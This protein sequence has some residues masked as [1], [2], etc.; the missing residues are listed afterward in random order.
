MICVKSKYDEKGNLLSRISSGE[1]IFP[2]LLEVEYDD[3]GNLISQS[4]YDRIVTEDGKENKKLKLRTDVVYDDTGRVSKITTPELISIHDYKEVSVYIPLIHESLESSNISHTE[5]LLKDANGNDRPDTTV[6]SIESSGEE[7]I[8]ILTIQYDSIRV[9]E[10]YEKGTN[11]LICTE[12]CFFN[13]KNIV[14]YERRDNKGEVSN[15]RST[16][17]Y[18]SEGNIIFIDMEDYS[19]LKTEIDKFEYFQY[20]KIEE[21]KSYNNVSKKI[22]DM[23]TE[24]TISEETYEVEINTIEK[25]GEEFTIIKNNKSVFDCDTM[26]E[27][28]TFTILERTYDQ[29]YRKVKEVNNEDNTISYYSYDDNDDRLTRMVVKHLNTNKKITPFKNKNEV[30]VN[31]D[32]VLT[33]LSTFEDKIIDLTLTKYSNG[34]ISKDVKISYMDELNFE[35]KEIAHYITNNGED[36]TVGLLFDA[37][38]ETFEFIT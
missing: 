3:K 1:K 30:T 23:N 4:L 9:V 19:N 5:Y 21:Y 22:I 2:E 36:A 35:D 12:Y 18:D 10:S 28:D 38:Y 32:I 34:Y 26:T 37:L 17:E 6:Y 31:E 20:P 13:N 33:H 29:F 25:D 16:Y 8:G 15:I 24:E 14:C 11:N 7:E 27:P